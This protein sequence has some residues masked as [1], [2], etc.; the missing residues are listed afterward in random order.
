M[1]DQD[2]A[3]ID[4]VIDDI[5]NRNFIHLDYKKLKG[6]TDMYRVRVGKHRIIFKNDNDIIKIISVGKRDD[7]TY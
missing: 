4:K 7:T 1:S 3:N 2:Y 6:E 5:H